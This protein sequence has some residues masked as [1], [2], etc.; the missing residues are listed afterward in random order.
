M[1]VRP[2]GRWVFQNRYNKPGSAGDSIK[3]VFHPPL[4]PTQTIPTTHTPMDPFFDFMTQHLNIRERELRIIEHEFSFLQT[5]GGVTPEDMAH[6]R[7]NVLRHTRSQPPPVMIKTES[8][9]TDHT[10]S[11]MSLKSMLLDI[12]T[13]EQADQINKICRNVR[14]LLERE[15][16]HTFSRHHAT[17]VRSADMPRVRLLMEKEGMVNA[18]IRLS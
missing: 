16:I 8:K 13:T 12:I 11:T 5:C 14:P 15:G 7:E 2:N 17:H 18:T 10:S 4:T 9:D 6:I 1:R 3:K